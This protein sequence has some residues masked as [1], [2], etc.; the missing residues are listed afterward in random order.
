MYLVFSTSLHP[1]SR[2]RVLANAAVQ[3]MQELGQACE[4][5]D[6]AALDPL[7]PCNGHDCYGDPLVGQL[8]GKIAAANSL[9]GESCAI[10]E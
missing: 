8:S 9:S 4:L 10:T 6:L 1:N 5:L 2:R 7:P 3:Q